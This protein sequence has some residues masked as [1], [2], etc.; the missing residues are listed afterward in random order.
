MVEGQKHCIL[1]Q[2]KSLDTWP[3]SDASHYGAVVLFKTNIF[4]GTKLVAM[5]LWITSTVI[6]EAKL[7]R[8]LMLITVMLVNVRAL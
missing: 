8:F 5:E 2:L 4:I 3:H 7:L 1:H 6:I